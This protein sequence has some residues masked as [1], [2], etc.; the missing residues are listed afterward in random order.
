MSLAY[1]AWSK[2]L[3][4]IDAKSACGKLGYYGEN[5]RAPYLLCLLGYLGFLD[6]S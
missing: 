4:V 6:Q 5:I 3:G 1:I 2:F